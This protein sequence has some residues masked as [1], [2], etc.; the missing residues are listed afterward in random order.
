MSPGPIAHDRPDTPSEDA[1]NPRE[2]TSHAEHHAHDDHDHH[3]HDLESVRVAVVTVSSSRTMEDDPSGDLITNLL[4]DA[5]HE[6]IMREVIPDH[7]DR[8]RSHVDLLAR[9]SDLDLVITTGGTGVTPDDV[10]IEAITPLFDKTLPGFGELFRRRSES[11][12]GT[13]VIATRA[14]AG[15]AQ[16]TPVFCLPGSTNAT[17]LATEDILLPEI[18]HLAGLAQR[19]ADHH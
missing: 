11:E 17:R 15:I 4:Q 10:T 16:E 6:V 8:V 5:G 18:G 9:R 1:G 13:R 12:I 7:H 19:N 2:P 14:T 3:A